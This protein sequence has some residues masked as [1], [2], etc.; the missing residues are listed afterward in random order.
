LQAEKMLARAL[1]IRRRLGDV[2]GCSGILHNLARLKQ[3]SGALM[4]A[5]SLY[6]TAASLASR[7]AQHERTA[8][9]LESLAEIY[10]HQRNPGL[11]LRT[12]ERA[13]AIC[14]AHNLHQ[15]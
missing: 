2:R 5:A 15:R 7:H 8:L 4:E 10:D 13:R 14:H 1:R 9:A 12:L 3:D 11:A 6:V